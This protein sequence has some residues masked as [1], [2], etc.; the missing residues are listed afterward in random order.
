[1]VWFLC[2]R[3]QSHERVKVARRVRVAY[4][5]EQ[6]HNFFTV[7]LNKLLKHVFHIILKLNNHLWKKMTPKLVVLKSRKKLQVL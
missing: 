1:M 3:D 7:F 2:D 5:K 6:N 4:L